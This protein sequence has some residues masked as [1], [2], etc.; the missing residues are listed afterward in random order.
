MKYV[1]VDLHKQTISVCVMIQDANKRKV[2][3]RK[4]LA[5]AQTDAIAAYFQSLGTF[6]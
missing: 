6:Q 1:G 2:I 5:C 3:D 4:R